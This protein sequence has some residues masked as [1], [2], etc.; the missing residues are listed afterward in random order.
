MKRAAVV[1][2]AWVLYSWLAWYTGI[3]FLRLMWLPSVLFLVIMWA[4]V[5]L[6]WVL[7]GKSKAAPTV[8]FVPPAAPPRP[9]EEYSISGRRLR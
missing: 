8:G 7:G 6:Q 3:F 9:R 4:V 5:L 1:T 2:V